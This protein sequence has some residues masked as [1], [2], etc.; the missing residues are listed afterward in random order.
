MEHPEDTPESS[1]S[2]DVS[3]DS[4]YQSLSPTVSDHGTSIVGNTR[5]PRRSKSDMV[6]LGIWE[7]DVDE[8]I[9]MEKRGD[10]LFIHLRWFGRFVCNGIGKTVPQRSTK[11]IL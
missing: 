2:T 7:D 4:G 8:V 3:G 11:T 5:K 1:P 9:T 10:D 6:A